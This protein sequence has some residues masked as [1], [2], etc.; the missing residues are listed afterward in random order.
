MTDSLLAEWGPHDVLTLTINR[1]ERKNALDPELLS[2]LADAL[3]TDRDRASAVILRGAGT[4]AFSS[5]YD[6]SRL[7]GTVEDLEA[8]RHIGEAGAAL[9][10]C[11]APAVPRP[12][13]HRPG[14]AVELAPRCAPRL[15]R[16][17]PALS[18]AA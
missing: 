11:P 14:A 3:R 13:G 1:P 18:P 10:A 2:G 6:I 12:P 15:R 8:D 4:E 9:R 5:G 7:T 17:A 16:G